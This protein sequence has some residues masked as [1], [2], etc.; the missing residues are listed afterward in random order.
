MLGERA[1]DGRRRRRAI[2]IATWRPSRRS[3]RRRAAQL[4]ATSHALMARPSVSVKLSAA[5]SAL[6]A[7]QGG[8]ARPRAAAAPRRAGRGRT[9]ARPRPHHRRRGAGPPRSH[10]RPVRRRLLRS[11]ARWLAGP[12]A[13]R[14]GL[15][16]ARHPGAALAAAPVASTA[17][18][19]IPVRLVKGA[20]WDSE[21]KWAQERGLADYPV[22]TRKLHTDVS[23][24]ACVRL[25]LSRPGGVLSRSSPRTT[26]TRSP[27]VY[28]AGRPARR[29]SSSACTAWARR[30]TRR[31]S[32]ATSSTCPAAS[33]RRSGRTRTS[34]PTSC[35]AC[36]RTAPTPRSS[37]AWPTTRRRSTRSSAIPSRAWQRERGRS[38]CGCCRGRPRSMRPSASTA[39]GWR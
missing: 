1:Q 25:M 13:R 21:I 6:R 5:P 37:T 10:A 11:R 31:W 32:A 22:F 14:A 4:R 33:T 30:S 8:A 19:R 24:L 39:R 17:G 9:P 28:V 34:S 26:P 36:S 35:G 7:G 29:S 23:Y 16:Q 38:R 3:A 12:R 27:S 15:R 2:S 18:K 20:Y